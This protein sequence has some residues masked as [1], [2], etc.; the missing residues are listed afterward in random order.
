MALRKG[1][2]VATHPGD[3]SVDLVMT[4]NA[5]RLVGVQVMAKSASSRSGSVD[6]PAAPAR[7]NKWDVSE[8]SEQDIY[9]VVDYIGRTPI[10]TGFLFPQVNCVLTTDAMTRFDRHQ[11][12][13]VTY[14][15]GNGNMGI[16]HPSGMFVQ[17]GEDEEP[18]EIA[19]ADGSIT[20]DRNTGRRVNLTVSLAGRTVVL[21]LGKDGDVNLTMDGDFSVTCNKAGIKADRSVEIDTPEAHFTG[22]VR[23]DGDVIADGVSLVRHPHKNVQR[24]SDQSGEPVK[25]S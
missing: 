22:V 18:P 3:H 15:D 4:D 21:N 19:G 24:G 16:R 20:P 13:V 1:V 23:V 10:V 5:E 7:K 14:T 8:P 9:G 25:Q 12:D 11:S 6:L 17:I 2:V